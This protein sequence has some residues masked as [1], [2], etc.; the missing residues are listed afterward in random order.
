VQALD[1]VLVDPRFTPA[2][3]IVVLGDVVAGHCRVG[4][5]IGPP[6]SQSLARV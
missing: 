1:A 2:E 3:R 4:P 5:W 6:V